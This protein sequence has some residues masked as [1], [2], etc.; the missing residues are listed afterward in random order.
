MWVDGT[1]FSIQVKE[2]PGWTPLF[3]FGCSKVG[4]DVNDDNDLLEEEG[5]VHSLNDNENHSSDPFCIYDIIEKMKEQDLMGEATFGKD[6]LNSH[7]H[8]N[9]PVHEVDIGVVDPIYCS[10]QEDGPAPTS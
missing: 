3:V 9:S 10:Q 4:Y 8:E 6:G 1:L 2:A 7:V 5:R